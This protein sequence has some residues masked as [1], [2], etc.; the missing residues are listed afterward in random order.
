MPTPK[1]TPPTRLASS[2]VGGSGTR[3]LKPS[4]PPMA[5]ATAPTASALS[6]KRSTV[7]SVKRYTFT[8]RA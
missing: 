7:R 8:M 5:M 2:V 3:A 1:I 6:M 4:S